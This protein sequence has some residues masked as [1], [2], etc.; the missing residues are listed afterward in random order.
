MGWNNSLMPILDAAGVT[1]VA[2]TR[3]RHMVKEGVHAEL[4]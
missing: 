2:R 1:L 4:L 3:I